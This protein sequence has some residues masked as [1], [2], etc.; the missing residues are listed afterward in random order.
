MKHIYDAF[1]WFTVL[2]LKFLVELF[3]K[4][5]EHETYED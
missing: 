1:E 5:N 4:D 2:M 3:E